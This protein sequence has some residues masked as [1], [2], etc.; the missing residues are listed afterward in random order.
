MMTNPCNTKNGGSCCHGCRDTQKI[1]DRHHK[2]VFQF[3]GGKDSTAALLLLR[4]FWDKIT[5][6]WCNTGDAFPETKAIIAKFSSILP[7]FIE[8]NT[9]VKAYIA[10][11]GFPSDVV[12][13]SHTNLG[14]MLGGKNPI[15]ISSAYECTAVNLWIPTQAKTI[16]LGATL[17]IRGQRDQESMKSPVKSGHVENGI[18]YFFPIEDWSKEEVLDY[19]KE[20]NFE[21]PDHFH[22]EESS[23]DCMSCTAFCS[24][25]LDR[26]AWM[27]KN[28]PEK[29]NENKS[30]MEKVL[31]V[32]TNEKNYM[33]RMVA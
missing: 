16:E 20:Q 8:I 18:E 31:S 33:E 5:V 21:I 10:A 25:H 7:H 17:V 30:N 22:F 28:Y 23:L 26:M 13:I 2:I 29:Y 19:L 9:D 32:I 6:L 11:N 4:P 3:S 24:S 27:K 14:S 12:P 15:K 1:I